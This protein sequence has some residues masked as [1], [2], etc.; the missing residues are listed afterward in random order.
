MTTGQLIV[1]LQNYPP[2]TP[3][4]IADW[5]EGYQHPAMGPLAQMRIAH[6]VMAT[7]MEWDV[8][9]FPTLLIIGDLSEGA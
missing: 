6:D 3:V 5:N 9:K 8:R 1:L 4:A 2:D 7:N